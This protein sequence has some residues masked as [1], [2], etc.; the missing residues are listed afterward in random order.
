MSDVFG[1]QVANLRYV[2]TFVHEAKANDPIA[3]ARQIALYLCSVQHQRRALGFD[4]GPVFGTRLLGDSLEVYHSQWDSSGKVVVRPT[5]TTF[6]IGYFT[7]FL[8]CYIFLCKLA[9][10]ARGQVQAAFA[11]W[12]SEQD[13]QT[14]TMQRNRAA[15]AI[16]WFVYPPRRTNTSGGRHSRT[17]DDST[18]DDLGAQEIEEWHSSQAEGDDIPSIIAMDNAWKGAYK[19]YLLTQANLQALDQLYA[20]GPDALP[21]PP[22][23]DIGGWARQSIRELL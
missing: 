7:E 18:G 16:P 9:D 21:I 13:K 6:R 15:A 5:T 8:A 17:N 3:S 1:S 23:M 22:V 12:E 19:G 20:E 2:T 11:R 10:A 4:D 14:V